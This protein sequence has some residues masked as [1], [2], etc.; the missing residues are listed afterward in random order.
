MLTS[1]TKTNSYKTFKKLLEYK[2][3][4]LFFESFCKC[5]NCVETGPPR[6]ILAGL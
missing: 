2:I 4:S 3:T 5:Q 1:R 6:E